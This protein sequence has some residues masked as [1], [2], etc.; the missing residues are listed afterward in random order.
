M[1]AATYHRVRF[2]VGISGIAARCDGAGDG[3]AGV[4]A[5]PAVPKGH[6]V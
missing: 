6:H 1:R 3:V 5:D 2:C 4:S